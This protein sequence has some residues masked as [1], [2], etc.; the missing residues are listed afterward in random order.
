MGSSP[1]RNNG[2]AYG[3]IAIPQ[4]R[5]AYGI[6]A[7]PTTN[8]VLGARRGAIYGALRIGLKTVKPVFM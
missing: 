1:S 4:Q 3:I 2:H 8:G 6:I 7:I 5:H